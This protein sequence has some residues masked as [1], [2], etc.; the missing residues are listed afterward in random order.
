MDTGL[1]L[2][3]R[4]IMDSTSRIINGE[5]PR[6]DFIGTEVEGKT[7]GIVGLGAI[8]RAVAVKARLLGMIVVG[9]D[10]NIDEDDPV[11]GE[12]DVQYKKFSDLIRISDAITMHVPLNKDTRGLFG[13]YALQKNDKSPVV[14]SSAIKFP[15]IGGEDNA[16]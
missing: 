12:L 15:E 10:V 5:W 2:L 9:T 8:G 1:L 16:F 14:K 4:G 7:L 3:F 6:G 13:D 11:W